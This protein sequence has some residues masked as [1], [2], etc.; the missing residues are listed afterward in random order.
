MKEKYFKGKL[1]T[2]P[3]LITT[4]DVNSLKNRDGKF[5]HGVTRKYPRIISTRTIPKENI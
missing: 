2:P 5:I 1:R 4:R 3:T